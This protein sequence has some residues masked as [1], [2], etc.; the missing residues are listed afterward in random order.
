MKKLFIISAVLFFTCSSFGQDILLD[1]IV[2]YN[3]KESGDSIRIR[4]EFWE[5][6]QNGNMLIYD[7]YDWDQE[8]QEWNYRDSLSTMNDGVLYDIVTTTEWLYDISGNQIQEIGY[9]Y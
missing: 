3:Y 8:K 5:Y 6:D 7:V 1:S 2:Y 4:K 9:R